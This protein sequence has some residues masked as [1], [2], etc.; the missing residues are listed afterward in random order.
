MLSFDGSCGYILRLEVRKRNQAHEAG[1]TLIQKGLDLHS[2]ILRAT[3]RAHGAWMFYALNTERANP[4]MHR[5]LK[6]L[7]MANDSQRHTV[8]D[9]SA[10]IGFGRCCQMMLFGF[11]S[12]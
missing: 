7:G 11:L 5:L 2:P 10:N 4:E 12:A 3:K 9:L 6:S 8:T 1:F